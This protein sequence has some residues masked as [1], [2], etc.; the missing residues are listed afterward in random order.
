[1]FGT[2]RQVTCEICECLFPKCS[3]DL[4]EKNISLVII[5]FDTNCSFKITV[6]LSFNGQIF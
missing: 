2:R 6:Y 1:M 3:E 4:V 5:L